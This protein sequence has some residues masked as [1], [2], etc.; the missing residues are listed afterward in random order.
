MRKLI[1]FIPLAGLALPAIASA[2]LT[3]TG[4]FIQRVGIL[5]QRSTI[6]IA[7][8]ALLFFFWGLVQFIRK[9]GDEKAIE[10]GRRFMIWGTVALFVMVSIWGLTALIGREFAVNV[11]PAPTIPTFNQ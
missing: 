2:Q 6:V 11:G 7:G 4:L 3:T 9:A 8:I 5:V 1:K 10:E